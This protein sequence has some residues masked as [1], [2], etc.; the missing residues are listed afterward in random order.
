MP[1]PVEKPPHVHDARMRHITVEA[2]AAAVDIPDYRA[3]LAARREVTPTRD[4]G[5][6]AAY[7]R[8]SARGG[9]ALAAADALL[10][11]AVD[12]TEAVHGRSGLYALHYLYWTEP[13]VQAYA[14]SGDGRYAHRFAGLIDEWYAARDQVHGQWPGLDV[15]WYTLGVACRSQVLIRAL[16]TLGEVLPDDTWHRIVATLLG[17]AR[18]LA[19]EHDVFRHGNWQLVGCAVLVEI[20]GYL[21]EFREAPAWAALAQRR[22]VEHLALDVYADGGHYERSPTYHAMCL[23]GL[24]NAALYDDALRDHPRLRVMHDWLLAMATPGG[25]VPPFNDSHLVSAGEPLLRGWHLYGD[26]TYLAAARRWLPRQRIAETLA[27]LA[28]R[29]VPGHVPQPPAT[30]SVWLPQSKF[31]V[32]RS[33]DYHAG[34]NCGPHIEHELESHSH[35]AAL[36]LVL[37]G[38]GQPLAWEAGGPDSYD[39]PA[40]QTWYRATRAHNTIRVGEADIGV[41]HDAEVSVCAL[42][43]EVDVLIAAHNGWSSTHRRV[44]LFLRGEPPYWVVT[45]EYHAAPYQWQLHGLQAWAGDPGTGLHGGDG[46]GLLVLPAGQPETVRTTEGPTRVPG[47]DGSSV[48]ANLA[49]LALHYLP[50]RSSHVLVPYAAAPPPVTV[51]EV[52]GQLRVAHAGGL[53]TLGEGQLIR[54]ADGQVTAAAMWAA[55]QIVHKGRTLV[56]GRVNALGLSVHGD[57][58]TMT[59][60]AAGRTALWVDAA[61]PARLDGIPITATRVDG[62]SRLILP[63]AGRWSVQIDRERQP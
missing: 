48:P 56:A 8:G 58:Y 17:G 52:D 60:E 18:W 14:L 39:D 16:H 12:F 57:R 19:E 37:W 25:V 6:W 50:G 59:A 62:G 23:G 49:G 15:I 26:P 10:D 51:S 40:Y 21:P 28:P 45:D 4:P 5:R 63:A 53:D 30:G 22:L 43:P 11:R 2:L 13:L 35:L 1:A 41:E 42:L 54:T 9:E 24:Q 32:L 44:V 61:G 3:H 38:Y 7:V 27:W 34:V 47:G 31:A 20:A 55:D 33:G 29:A 36:D 46:P